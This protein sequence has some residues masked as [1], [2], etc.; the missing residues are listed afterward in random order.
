MLFFLLLIAHG[1]P[2][3]IRTRNHFCHREALYQLSYGDH[4]EGEVVPLPTG[5]DVRACSA[6]RTMESGES[7]CFLLVV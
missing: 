4:T 1:V 6:K 2:D 3:G 7:H 5:I